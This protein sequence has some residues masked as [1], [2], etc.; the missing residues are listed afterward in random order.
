M[1]SFHRSFLSASAKFLKYMLHFFRV[2]YPHFLTITKKKI[3]TV[4][5]RILDQEVNNS[6]KDPFESDDAPQGIP[7]KL[8]LVRL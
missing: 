4:F 3:E 5:K 2:C 7:T 8:I 1:L 6:T